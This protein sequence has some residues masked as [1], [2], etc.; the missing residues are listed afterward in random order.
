MLEVSVPLVAGGAPA[1][2]AAPATR[3]NAV[4]AATAAPSAALLRIERNRTGT[5]DVCADGRE[6]FVEAMPESRNLCTQAAGRRASEPDHPSA[7]GREHPVPVPL[8][9]SGRQATVARITAGGV[10][11]SSA[12]N[13]SRI[14]FW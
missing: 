12:S 3:A 11:G 14:F 1:M 8:P 4:S 6:D 5:G 2:I 10:L 7:A 13:S 9:V